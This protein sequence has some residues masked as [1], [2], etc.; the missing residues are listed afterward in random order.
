[1]HYRTPRIGFLE[2]VE[3]FLRRF[4]D[5]ERLGDASFELGEMPAGTR[6]QVIVPAAP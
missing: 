6:P 4:T 2:T 1:M 3:P 5:V